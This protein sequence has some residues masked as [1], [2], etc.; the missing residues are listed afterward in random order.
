MAVRSTVPY[1]FLMSVLRMSQQGAPPCP[2]VKVACAVAAM[3]QVPSVMRTA[4]CSGDS[5]L[6]T[7]EPSCA[8]MAVLIKRM[9][10]PPMPSGRK[11]TGGAGPSAGTGCVPSVLG[12]RASRPA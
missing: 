1:A 5:I 3:M 8:H 7:A 6:P 4:S 10:E 11:S 2:C 9:I 12:I